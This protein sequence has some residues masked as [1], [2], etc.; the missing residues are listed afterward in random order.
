MKRLI[1]LLLC[2]V[3]VFALVAC[4]SSED[5]SDRGGKKKNEKNEEKN[6]IEFEELVVADNDDCVIKLTEIE[7][8]NIFGFTIK[9]YLENKSEDT[10]Y[11]FS[12]AMSAVNGVQ[13]D[14]WFSCIV[15]PGKKANEEIT[16]SD[17]VLE[18]NGI[19]YTDLELVFQYRNKD[20]FFVDPVVIDAIHVYPYGEDKAE[21]FVKKD[22]DSDTVVVDNDDVK[23]VVV[24]YEENELTGYSVQFYFEN[25]SEDKTYMI[26]TS[27]VYVNDTST[28]PVLYEELAPGKCSFQD[29]TWWG[30]EFEDNNIDKVEKIEMILK[31]RDSEDLFADSIYEESVTLKP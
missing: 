17:T 5:D 2:L 27:D 14:P 20:D 9:A 21:T 23:V 3:M 31:V 10:S 30:T 18:R 7:D 25:K 29:M 26:T 8:D 15:E 24:G 19:E 16:F 11:M 4:G 12:L 28:D 6:E 1:A 13:V 22:K